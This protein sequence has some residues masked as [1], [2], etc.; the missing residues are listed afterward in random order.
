MWRL[1]KKLF[2][3]NTEELSHYL[4]SGGLG[5]EFGS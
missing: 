1:V 4:D 3:S 5:T 2:A